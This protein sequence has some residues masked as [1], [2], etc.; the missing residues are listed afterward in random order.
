MAVLFLKQMRLALNR[1]ILFV[2]SPAAAAAQLIIAKIIHTNRIRLEY[3]IF[4]LP[5]RTD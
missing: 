1:Y 5:V 3:H 2:E 4:L